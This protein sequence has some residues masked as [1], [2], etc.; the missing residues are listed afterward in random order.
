MKQR[1]CVR[2]Y[3]ERIRKAN[4]PRIVSVGSI[5]N[6]ARTDKG[7]G[8]PLP[9]PAAKSANSRKVLSQASHLSSIVIVGVSGDCI[10]PDHPSYLS[11]NP[12]PG[13][14]GQ[15]MGQ[16]KINRNAITIGIGHMGQMGR[17]I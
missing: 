1:M 14:M 11:T 3:K 7:A 5:S 10:C 12:I 15:I 16:I 17:M 6:E 13:Q 2:R 4:G 8:S 9:S